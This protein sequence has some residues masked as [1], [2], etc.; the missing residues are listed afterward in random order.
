LRT[1]ALIKGMSDLGYVVAN[2][3]ERDLALGYDDFLG[4]TSEA[5]FPF[6]SANIVDRDTREPLFKPYVILDVDIAGADEPLRVG[7]LGV[8]RF[9]PVFLKTGPGESELIIVPPMEAVKRYYD[10]VR[11]RS[12][13]VVVMAALHRDDAHIIAREVTGIDLVL[14]AYGAMY[15]TQLDLEGDTVISY[16]G[17]QGRRIGETRLFLDDRSLARVLP[18][19]HNLTAQYPAVAEVQDYVLESLREIGRQKAAAEAGVTGKD[20]T[21]GSGA[22]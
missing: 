7:M 22:S 6:I 16:A 13:V 20:G 17:N 4:R 3:G 1:R 9:N 12:D 19:M 10:E 2:V 8:V 5:T 18:F 21:E 15:S 14:G 11:E